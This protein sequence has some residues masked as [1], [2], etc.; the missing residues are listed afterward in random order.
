MST[1]LYFMFYTNYISFHGNYNDVPRSLGISSRSL[2]KLRPIEQQ[3]CSRSKCTVLAEGENHYFSLRPQRAPWPL[4]IQSCSGLLYLNEIDRGAV[5][6]F[7]QSCVLISLG[8]CH[9]Q[10]VPSCLGLAPRLIEVSTMWVFPKG[11]LSIRYTCQRATFWLSL[12][13]ILYYWSW[14]CSVSQ[15]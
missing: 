8:A 5:G 6:Y 7:R 2:E 12:S 14:K 11:L 13:P 15:E 9:C 10:Y 4:E 1:E 3:C